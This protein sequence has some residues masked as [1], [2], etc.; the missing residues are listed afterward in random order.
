[1]EEDDS[2]RFQESRELENKRIIL[3]VTGSI[4]SIMSIKLSREL[5]RRGA[6]V[7][8]VLSDSAKNMIDS[9]TLEYATGNDV[10]DEVGGGVQ[11]VRELGKGGD[12]DL[13]LIAPATANTINKL[14]NGVCDTPVTLFGITAISNDKKVSIAPAMHESMLKNEITE[15]NVDKLSDLGVNIIEPRFESGKA[16]LSD[17]S[18]IIFEVKRQLEPESLGNRRLLITAGSTKE[19]IDDVRF[20]TNSGSGRM[21]AY[22]AEE[23][24]IRGAEVTLILGENDLDRLPCI[25]NIINVS[26]Y[27]EMRDRVQE[28][29]EK[30]KPSVFISTAAVSDFKVDKKEGKLSSSREIELSLRPREKI[31]DKVLD[32]SP[33]ISVFSFKLEKEIEEAKEEALDIVE[34]K[35]IKLVVA[36]GVKSM[37]TENMECY[38]VS[39][40]FVNKRKGKKRN[41][42][43]DILD[44]LERMDR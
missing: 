35:E 15:S 37:G 32:K 16:K 12:A 9:S 34:D 13:F 18:R 2:I 5:I 1:M 3:G 29:I 10:V 31:I 43:K 22:L 41:V 30:N 26:S 38:M 36:N 7:V 21:G 14:A 11:H 27:E 42:A 28:Q 6:D 23:A 8:A 19:E 17:L 24:A 44:Y 40:E 33:E 4:A 25:S 39:N 20:L